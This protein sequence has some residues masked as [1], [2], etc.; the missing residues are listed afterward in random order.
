MLNIFACFLAQVNFSDKVFSIR[1]FSLSAHVILSLI[2]FSLK[3]LFQPDSEFSFT[4]K[5]RTGTYK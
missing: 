5:T 1:P 3:A 4:Y 2:V